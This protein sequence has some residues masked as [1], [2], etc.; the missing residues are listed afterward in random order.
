MSLVDLML[1]PSLRHRRLLLAGEEGVGS[2]NYSP[3][4]L[5]PGMSSHGQAYLVNLS[6]TDSGGEGFE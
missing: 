3:W 4:T 5:E 1:L 2:R 6:A